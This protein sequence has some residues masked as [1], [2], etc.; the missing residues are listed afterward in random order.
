L[1][2]DNYEEIGSIYLRIDKAGIKNLGKK[3]IEIV[4]VEIKRHKITN[5]AIQQA[6]RYY[7]FSHKVYIASPYKPSKNI[8]ENLR[9]LGLGF[10]LI[11]CKEKKIKEIIKPCLNTP[12]ENIIIYWLN[13]C[14]RV[15]RCRICHNFIR[16]DKVKEHSFRV[17]KMSKG[18]FEITVLCNNCEE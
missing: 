8:A 10:L 14:F 4:S 6:M 16:K 3:N 13:N 7:D 12:K 17:I 15:Y 1:P 2:R 5:N 18:K 9:N 11:N